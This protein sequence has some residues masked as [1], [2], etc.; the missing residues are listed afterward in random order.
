MCTHARTHMHR[1]WIHKTEVTEGTAT[2]T[3]PHSALTSFK[4]SSS[5]S[6]SAICL[7][8]SCTSQGLGTER[9]LYNSANGSAPYLDSFEC[10]ILFDPDL[11]QNL[12][13]LVRKLILRLCRAVL[14]MLYGYHGYSHDEDFNR[15]ASYEQLVVVDHN[16][17]L[18]SDLL[19]PLFPVIAQ[20]MPKCVRA[21]INWSG[22]TSPTW[23]Y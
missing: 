3:T 7:W 8:S 21:P 14:G 23:M 5:L 6:I 19:F 12:H 11:S 17:R 18:G 22:A 2:H 10:F 1:A 13:F 15:L 16:T 9:K 20:W 4:N